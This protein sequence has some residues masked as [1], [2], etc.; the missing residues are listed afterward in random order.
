MLCS[1]LY[2]RDGSIYIW[3]STRTSA[4]LGEH[5]QSLAFGA[6]ANCV[7]K[8]VRDDGVA[9]IFHPRILFIARRFDYMRMGMYL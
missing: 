9:R 4:T 8:E 7:C 1:V 6:T 3:H 2:N 5:G